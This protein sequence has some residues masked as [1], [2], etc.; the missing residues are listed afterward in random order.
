[1]NDTAVIALTPIETVAHV[2]KWRRA[3]EFYQVSVIDQRAD[4]LA[5]ENANAKSGHGQCN[6]CKEGVARKG[7]GQ[8]YLLCCCQTAGEPGEI[9]L[10][11][12]CDD[13]ILK[14]FP[15][16]EFGAGREKRRCT[17]PRVFELADFL[18]DYQI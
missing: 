16:C 11:C 12:E 1:M 6:E 3:D 15:R 10:R 2:R 8:F 9:S 5:R 18:A 7:T 17:H 14:E 4:I 13:G